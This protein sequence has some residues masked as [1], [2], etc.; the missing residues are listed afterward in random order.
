MPDRRIRT[1]AAAQHAARIAEWAATGRGLDA[2]PDEFALFTALHTCAYRAARCD[3]GKRVSAIER[4]E[5]SR[6]WRDIRECIVKKNLGLV[7]TMLGRIS[8][9]DPDED[10]R[11]SEAMYGLARAVERFNPWKGYRFST[12]ACNAIFRGAGASRQDDRGGTVPCSRSS[13]M[14]CL[15]RPSEL[16]DSQA[17]LYAERLN[18]AMSANL[19]ELTELEARIIA[20]RF[21]RDR[22]DRLTLQ[23]IA[24]GVGLSKERVR[25][26]QDLALEKAARDSGGRSDPAVITIWHQD[27]IRTAPG[28]Q[29][30]KGGSGQD[31]AAGASDRCLWP[32]TIAAHR[33]RV[34]SEDM[35]T[36]AAEGS[37]IPLAFPVFAVYSMGMIG[38]QM[39][40]DKNN[41]LGR[42]MTR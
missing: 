38:A 36:A 25:Q 35:T 42:R 34:R 14:S 1:Q 13:T 15:E 16:P 37:A 32:A 6:R 33:Y 20:E 28:V 39:G 10:D 41:N 2:E 21:P 31:S 5:W 18:R 4:E 8:S 22:E 17:A 23:K 7:Y 30:K 24:V 26:I 9:C 3:P 29:P 11:L 19:A 27:R 12:Y 40:A